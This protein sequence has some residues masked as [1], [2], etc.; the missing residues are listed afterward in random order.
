MRAKPRRTARCVFRG[1]AHS[2]SP[3]LEKSVV[4]EFLAHGKSGRRVIIG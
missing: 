1:R 2:V 4:D 3:D